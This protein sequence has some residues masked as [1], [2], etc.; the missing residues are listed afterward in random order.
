LELLTEI[1]NKRFV[2]RV[3]AGGNVGLG[4]FY[5]SLHLAGAL[6]KLGNSV[7]FVH[8]PSVFWSKLVAD[9]FPF[10]SVPLSENQIEEQ[11]KLVISRKA[12][13]FYVDGII[14]FD[15]VFI[16]LIKK[17]AKVVFYQNLSQSRGLADVFILPTLYQSV[18]FFH[19]FN[20][21]TRIYQ[22]LKYQIFKEKIHSLKAKQD[23]DQV[24]NIAIT[25]GGSDPRNT[26]KM[27]YEMIDFSRYRNVCFLFFYGSDY[28][29]KLPIPNDYSAS[30]SFVPY[31]EESILKCDLL[32]SCFGVSTYEFMS[33]GMPIIS[34]GH[35]MTNADAATYVDVHF[36]GLIS[37]GLIDEVNKNKLNNVLFKLI[38]DKAMRSKLSSNAKKTV[39]FNGIKEIIKILKNL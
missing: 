9:N 23:L 37:I 24:R 28:Q 16:T 13:V 25:T 12:D 2:F 3:D 31:N 36:K 29:H 15:T 33:L 35:Q 4:H 5:R 27:L 8:Q 26:M 32:I 22:G 17:Q 20:K 1:H 18:S 19:N 14:D 30:I 11:Y 38:S 10:D 21:D 6:K 7:I 34:F 39:N